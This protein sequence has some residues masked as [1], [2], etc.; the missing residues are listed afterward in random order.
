M[1]KIC[2]STYK[3]YWCQELGYIPPITSAITTTCNTTSTTALLLKETTGTTTGF[4]FSKSEMILTPILK[5]LDGISKKEEFRKI[6]KLMSSD[7]DYSIPLVLYL[8]LGE[9]INLSLE[10]SQLE[11]KALNSITLSLLKTHSTITWT[12]ATKDTLKK[13]T[14]QP[15]LSQT[16]VTTTAKHRI[17]E[18]MSSMSS[19][20]AEKQFSPLQTQTKLASDLSTDD[21]IAIILQIL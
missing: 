9:H 14:I 7:L 6:L 21:W 4:T 12:K 18:D 1:G 2:Q 16:C 20:A 10:P 11:F 13:E 15:E 17:G 19:K 5:L 3:I 8:T